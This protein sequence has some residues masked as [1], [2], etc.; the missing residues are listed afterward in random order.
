MKET[1]IINLIAKDIL[2]GIIYCT[3]IEIIDTTTAYIY[4][5]N[6]L[7]SSIEFKKIEKV[8][9]NIYNF[10]TKVY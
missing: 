10:Y 4:N 8:E 9:K 3:K 5:K 1:L 7:I 2:I 6:E